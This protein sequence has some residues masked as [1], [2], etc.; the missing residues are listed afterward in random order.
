MRPVSVLSF[1]PSRLTLGFL[2]HAQSF[3]PLPP[4]LKK[5]LKDRTDTGPLDYGIDKKRSSVLFVDSVFL[6][7]YDHV[8]WIPKLD[9]KI[10]IFSNLQVD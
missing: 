6:N 8:F 9:A 3:T 7:F 2:I 10:N 1:N 5:R 4:A